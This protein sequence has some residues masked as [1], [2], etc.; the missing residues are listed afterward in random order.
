MALPTSPINAQIYSEPANG[1]RFSYSSLNNGWLPKDR[2][3][4]NDL[5]DVNETVVGAGNDLLV[6]NGLTN[7]WE[8]GIPA[9]NNAYVTRVNSTVN[10]TNT[11]T[12]E[13]GTL[14]RN[15][16]T[17]RAWISS[18][19][20]PTTGVRYFD[21]QVATNPGGANLMNGGGEPWGQNFLAPF[22]VTIN[23][24]GFRMDSTVGLLSEFTIKVYDGPNGIPGGATQIAQGSVYSVPAINL[25]GAWVDVDFALPIDLVAGNTYSATIEGTTTTE[26]PS[27][28]AN[29]LGTPFPTTGGIVTTALIPNGWDLVYR[30]GYRET[31]I[32]TVWWPIQTP[33]GT[34]RATV[35]RGAAPPVAPVDGRLWYNTTLSV[36]FVYDAENANWIE[37]L[38]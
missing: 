16:A 17:G 18:S 15:T 2:G 5:E 19:F 9:P 31:A 11:N 27:H 6:F 20:A 10:P 4:I 13:V 26:R 14:W 3:D 28:N 21:Q 34:A 36:L 1:R 37:V 7:Q 25:P 30:Y 29:P 8:P 12:Y 32:G 38:Q 35:F 23:T 33:Q 22:N 24:F